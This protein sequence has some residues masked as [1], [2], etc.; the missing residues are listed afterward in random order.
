MNHLNE[1][2]NALD[3]QRPGEA[4]EHLGQALALGRATGDVLA[5]ET[6]ISL[7]NYCAWLI[8][9]WTDMESIV[10]DFR[11]ARELKAA[12]ASADP[13]RPTMR[14]AVAREPGELELAD[15]LEPEP[16]AGFV[17]IRVRAV[18]LNR[19]E[20]RLADGGWPVTALSP[21]APL[22]NGVECAGEVVSSG[23]SLG[24]LPVL[25]NGT[26][27]L[28]C[29][30]ALG[31]G[32][33]GTHAQYVVVPRWGV[34]PVPDNGEALSWRELAA[35]PLSYGTAAGSLD[36][37]DC[38]PGDTV[39]VRGGT[40][41]LGLATIALAKHT[42]QCVVIATSRRSSADARL[43]AAGADIVLIEPNIRAQVRERFPDGVDCALEGIGETTLKD[44]MHCVRR[45]GVMCQT[46]ALTDVEGFGLHLL[47]EVPSAVKV[48]CFESDGLTHHVMAPLVG[49][50]IDALT[51][52]ALQPSIDPTEFSLEEYGQ[53]LDFLD[54]PDRE[55]KV[56]VSLPG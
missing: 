56:V 32:I 52:G 44:T 45:G 38:D 48:T 10:G 23:D 47:G 41:A 37:M 24:S 22:I 34:V 20:K 43:R 42:L 6:A 12:R 33:D 5:E 3:L 1:A 36:A 53:A 7:R 14:A 30:S 27:V 55:G 2:G 4:L 25:P 13:S 51:A 40:S 54:S 31:R 50:L 35:I 18:G 29:A 28:A 49:R 26:R 17:K 21:V 8:G 46:G 16:L 11:R 19:T 39:L 9:D 15:V